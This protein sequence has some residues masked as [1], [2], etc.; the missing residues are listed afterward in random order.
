M[1]KD[2]PPYIVARPLESNIL[3]WHFVITG[4]PDC[5]YEGGQ[6]WGRLVFPAEY[7]FKPPAI[8]MFTPS[9]RF[10]PKSR[11]CLSISD[12]HPETWNPSWSIS[13]ILIG[14]LSFMNEESNSVGTVTASDPQRRRLA[15]SSFSFNSKD[16]LF[17]QLFPDL[18]IKPVANSSPKKPIKA[19]QK[20]VSL[21]NQPAAASSSKKRR[22][23]NTQ[24]IVI[25]ATPDKQK[26]TEI[27]DLID[28]SPI[29]RKKAAPAPIYI[30]LL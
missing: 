22:H 20:I 11:L 25:D 16:K 18:L 19:S 26:P 12:F 4:P 10:Q 15:L 30:D 14:L 21:D 6:Y 13:L 2:P 3:E 7:P 24:P 8:Y 5:P 1:Q 29:P 9:G 23:I 27:I 17:Q 28:D